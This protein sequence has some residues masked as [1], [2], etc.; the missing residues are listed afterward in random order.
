MVAM[1]ILACLVV[2]NSLLD[3][4]RGTRCMHE[5]SMNVFRKWAQLFDLEHLKGPKSAKSRLVT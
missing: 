2:E 5:Q 3:K 1:A 4:E